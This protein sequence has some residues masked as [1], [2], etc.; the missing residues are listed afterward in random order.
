[1]IVTATVYLE[2]VVHSIVTV[3]IAILESGES[4]DLIEAVAAVF[5]RIR[6]RCRCWHQSCNRK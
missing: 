6:Q 5:A 1:M 4:G 3:V 2:L